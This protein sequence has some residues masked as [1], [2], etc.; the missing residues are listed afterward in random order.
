MAAGGGRR[1][2]EI[3]TDSHRQAPVTAN[4]QRFATVRALAN[5]AAARYC[6]AARASVAARGRF[7]VVLSGGRT[8][9]V[10]FEA[11]RSTPWVEQ[12]PWCDSHFFWSDERCVPPD[13]AGSNYGLAQRELLAHVPIPAGHVHRAPTELGSP[14][15]AGRAWE[16]ALRG[17]F[18]AGAG[19]N[20]FPEFDLVL[21][22]IGAD[23]HTAS[24]FPGAPAL[25]AASHWVAATDPMGDP[26]VSRLTLT[27]PVLNRA[28]EVIFLAAGPDKRAVINSITGT[29]ASRRAGYPAARVNPPRPPV[30]LY[31]E[32]AL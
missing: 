27:L 17:F 9:A 29:G 26:P 24:L 16:H 4:V 28:R 25:E 22:G 12:A 31:S 14:E 5:E 8:P 21:L 30:W 23:G 1:W 15:Q 10:L 18:G 13:H 11:L 2:P 19:K 7:C 20:V 32:T 6:D 3:T